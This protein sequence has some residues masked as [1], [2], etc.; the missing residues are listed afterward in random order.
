MFTVFYLQD[1]TPLGM[2]FRVVF[3]QTMEG[4]DT[5]IGGHGKVS[6]IFFFDASLDFCT[7]PFCLENQL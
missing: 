3:R 5:E 4:H 1:T 6:P 7:P 2:D